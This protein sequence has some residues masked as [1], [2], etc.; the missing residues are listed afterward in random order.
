MIKENDMLL[1]VL[2]NKDFN[3]LDFQAVGLN[4][5]NTTLHSEDDYKKSEKITSRSEF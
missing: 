3:V 2:S 1:N 5:S 4:A